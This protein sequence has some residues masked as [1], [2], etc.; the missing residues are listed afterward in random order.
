[1]DEEVYECM[2]GKKRLNDLE[3]DGSMGGQIK[4]T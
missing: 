1:M 2:S 4:K 3:M